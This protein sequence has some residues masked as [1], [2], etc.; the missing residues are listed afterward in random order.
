ML[1][2]KLSL[3]WNGLFKIVALGPAP[4]SDTP[5]N[6]P[7][8]R[9]LLFLDLP[10]YL[11]RRV[12]NRRFAVERCK[13]CQNPDDSHDILGTYLRAYRPPHQVKPLQRGP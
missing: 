7:L 9:K 1:K 8:Q 10:T 3:N 5:N 12:S 11:L 2:T 13:P 4:A 6:R